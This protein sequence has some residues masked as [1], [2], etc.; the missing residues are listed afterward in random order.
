MLFPEGFP[1]LWLGRGGTWCP[2]GVTARIGWVQ[3]G[4]LLL[5]VGLLPV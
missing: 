5:P 1:L 4:S 3:E 2:S